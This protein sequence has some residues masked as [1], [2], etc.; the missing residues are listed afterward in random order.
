MV[1]AGVSLTGFGALCSPQGRAL[2][3]A[4]LAVVPHLPIL[5]TDD[6]L[7]EIDVGAWQGRIRAD[8]WPDEPGED[9]PDGPLALYENA[10]G[11]EGFA[12]LEARCRAFLADL[13]DPTVIVTHGVTS[14]MLRAVVLGQGR[15]GLGRMPGGQGVVFHLKDGVQR[16]LD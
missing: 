9:G 12:G 2:E 8:L 10:P 4:A 7:C 11:G 5:R 16:Q 3:T 13:S 6:R 14:R 1:L 15:D